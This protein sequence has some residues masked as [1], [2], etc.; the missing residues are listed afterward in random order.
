[1]SNDEQNQN[2][3]KSL[4]QL[5]DNLVGA[6]S[7]L[8]HTSKS[9]EDLRIGF[10]K[11]LEP[12]LKELGVKITPRYERLGKEAASVYRGRPDAVHGLVIIEYEPPHSFKSQ[13]VVEHAHNQL[14]D[15]ITA[16]ATAAKETPF[17]G[18]P[19]FIGVGFDGEQIFFTKYQSDKVQPNGERDKKDVI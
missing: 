14:V 19:K 4:V 11:T 3:N 13:G 18:D 9:E 8:M 5:A 12:T 1:M 2:N 15:Y 10:E 17:V 7:D 6:V 16:E